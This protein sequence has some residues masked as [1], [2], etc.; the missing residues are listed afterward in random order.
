M[1]KLKNYVKKEREKNLE[2]KYCVRSSVIDPPLKA[3]V[4]NH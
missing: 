3:I 4:A 2:S 1:G